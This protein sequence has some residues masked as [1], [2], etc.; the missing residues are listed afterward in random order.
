MNPATG[1][2]KLNFPDKEIWE[3]EETCA[4]DVAEKGGITL[5]EV[6]ANLKA[7]SLDLLL[8]KL[9][10]ATRLGFG[11]RQGITNGL[12]T[13]I[14][15][16]SDG[17]FSVNGQAGFGRIVDDGDTTKKL[18]FE[19]SG[20]TTGTTR[21]ITAPNASGTAVLDTATQTLT[22]KTLT[23]PTLTTPVL[24]KTVT[25]DRPVTGLAKLHGRQHA[26]RCVAMRVAGEAFAVTGTSGGHA[27][28]AA[29]GTR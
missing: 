29:A 20:I 24:G 7:V 14:P 19:V 12:V 23:S 17:T 26:G 15:D 11:F 2:I 3:L 22:N 28:G 21:T 10:V 18:A 9:T 5:E 4:L 8:L 27:D 6:G 13:L 16:Q 25:L 1:S